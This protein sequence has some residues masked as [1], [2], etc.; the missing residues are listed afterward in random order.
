MSLSERAPTCRYRHSSDVAALSLGACQSSLHSS[1]VFLMPSPS[2]SALDL[3]FRILYSTVAFPLTLW[4]RSSFITG[5]LAS[6]TSRFFFMLWRKGCPRSAGLP[7]PCRLGSP[8]LCCTS[9][10]R[11]HD[12]FFPFVGSRTRQGLLRPAVFQR[13]M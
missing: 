11:T 2:L 8:A 3:V 7:M 9:F 12:G 1:S 10:R 13:V 4:L 5:F 6:T